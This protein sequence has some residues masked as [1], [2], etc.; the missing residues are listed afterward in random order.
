MGRQDGVNQPRSSV[1]QRSQ[2]Y[3]LGN[4]REEIA[5]APSIMCLLYIPIPFLVIFVSVKGV[6]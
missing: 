4:L 2:G 5:H 6:L 3:N 1:G